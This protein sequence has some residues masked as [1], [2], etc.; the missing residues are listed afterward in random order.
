MLM[1]MA[2]WNRFDIESYRNWNVVYQQSTHETN[3]KIVQCINEIWTLPD[4][5]LKIGLKKLDLN[6]KD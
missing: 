6:I 2:S 3:T 5:H 4:L 1:P